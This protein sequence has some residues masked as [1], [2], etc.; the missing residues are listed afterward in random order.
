M[1][2]FFDKHPNVDMVERIE[3]TA[4]ALFRL[5]R[6]KMRALLDFI[7]EHKGTGPGMP[8]VSQNEIH[9]FRFGAIRS[10]TIPYAKYDHNK[11]KAQYDKLA[12]FITEHCQEQ[13][14]SQYGLGEVMVPEDEVLD[15]IEAEIAKEELGG[16]PMPEDKKADR[17]PKSNVFMSGEFYKPTEA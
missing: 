7:E 1:S 6:D 8:Q 3:G 2:I 15:K 9:A 10:A 13:M 11:H 5:N 12:T 14:R 4:Y 16:Q 17:G